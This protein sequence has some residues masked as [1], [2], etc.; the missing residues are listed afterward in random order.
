MLHL[1]VRYRGTHVKVWFMESICEPTSPLFQNFVDLLVSKLCVSAE[2]V[3][4][5]LVLLYEHILIDIGHYEPA[6]MIFILTPFAREYV[7]S[8]V[9]LL[10]LHVICET[11][12]FMTSSEL[13]D[14]LPV[15]VPTILPSINS[16]AVDMRKAVVFVLVEIYLTVNDAL[17]PFLTTLQASQRKL[18]TIY[19]EKKLATRKA[20][21]A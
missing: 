17:F 10:A 2:T 5:P 11:I 15:L 7:P 12:H 1:L 3:A 8:Q 16:D 18:L 13:L 20:S 21:V 14:Q 9:R 19:I 4:A 6:K